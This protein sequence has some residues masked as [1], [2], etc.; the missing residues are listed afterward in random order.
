M[1]LYTYRYMIIDSSHDAFIIIVFYKQFFVFNIV[2]NL[3]NET[4]EL[5]IQILSREKIVSELRQRDYKMYNI[6]Y[7]VFI[8]LFI[9]YFFLYTYSKTLLKYLIFTIMP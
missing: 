5:V 6:N 9:M 3:M 4:R 7:D 8:L 2:Y 1:S